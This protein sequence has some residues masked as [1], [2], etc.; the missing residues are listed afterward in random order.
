MKN[1]NEPRKSDPEVIPFEPRS[2]SPRQMDNL[3]EV[4]TAIQASFVDEPRTAVEEAD[5][6]ISAAIRQLQET[7]EHERANLQKQWSEDGEASTEDLRL[8]LQQY[9]Q[10]FDRLMSRM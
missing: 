10:V 1:L 9:R 7:F 8:C 6:M 3:R 4:W 5:K 2:V